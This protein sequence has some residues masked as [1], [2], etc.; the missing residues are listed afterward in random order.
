MT[1]LTQPE[2]IALTG[3][4]RAK[5]QVEVLRENG[6]RFIV[7]ANGSPALTWEAVNNIIA[8]SHQSASHQANDGF[9]LEDMEL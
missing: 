9:N 7:R 6:V 3:A 2:I 8:P 5:K 1:L 4:E